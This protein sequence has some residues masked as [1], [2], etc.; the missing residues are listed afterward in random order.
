MVP[1]ALIAAGDPPSRRRK[2]TLAGISVPTICCRKRL[3]TS[4]ASK[5]GAWPMIRPM[6][7]A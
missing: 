6:A 5:S 2:A 1:V 3:R 7:R 4:T